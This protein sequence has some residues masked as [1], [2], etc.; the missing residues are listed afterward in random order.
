VV[1]HAAA[2]PRPSKSELGVAAQAI[3]IS[4]ADL[5]AAMQSGQSIAQVA[6]AHN[7]AAQKVIDAIVADL[8]AKAQARPNW[9]QL[10]ADQQAK[11]TD[12]IKQRATQ[13][14]NAVP[15]Q[16]VKD[17]QGAVASELLVAAK[18]IGI[19]ADQLLAAIQG[20]QSIAQVAQAH[21]VSPQTVIA[22]IV[23][24]LTA[25]AQA[26][27]A[28][29]NLTDAQKTKITDGIKQRVTNLVNATPNAQGRDQGQAKE[30]ARATVGSEL[31]IA[32]TTIGVTP[33]DLQQAIQ[34]GQT[35]AQV[36]QAHNVNPQTVIDAI[37]KDLTAKAQ[38]RPAWG[39]LTDAQKTKIT[40]GIKQ[41]VTNLVNN[42]AAGKKAKP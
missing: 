30:R 14:V 22:A 23:A 7:V 10:P 26:R 29:G 15:G 16:Q 39:K 31:A 2:A 8:T 9:S 38:A 24:D 40:D 33:T 28:W 17:R 35:I 5:M 3:G 41:R 42:T 11:I 12:A 4:E 20:G 6:Q 13:F 18:T 36:A 37:V 19:S 34:G 21:N 32:A 27:P 25:Q 1:S